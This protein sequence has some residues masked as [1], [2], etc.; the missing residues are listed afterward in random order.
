MDN[1]P[2]LGIEEIAFEVKDLSRSVAFYQDVIGL[3][4]LSRGPEEAWFRIGEQWL[5]LFTRD[6]IGS[7][8]H[9]ALRIPPPRRRADPACVG[10][11]RLCRGDNAAGRWLVRLCA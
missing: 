3:P 9:F 10:S 8:Q 11:P 1:I 4:L 2:V 7:G 6:R 5:A